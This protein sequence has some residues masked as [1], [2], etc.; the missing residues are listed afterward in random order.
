MNK[1][2]FIFNNANKMARTHMAH[3]IYITEVFHRTHHWCYPYVGLLRW[4][5]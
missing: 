4:S 3:Q 2:N 5:S 1:N